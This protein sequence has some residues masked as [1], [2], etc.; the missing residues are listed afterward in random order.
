MKCNYCGEEFVQT[1]GNQKYCS[2]HCRL[3]AKKLLDQQ[4]YT[5]KQE[6]EEPL[7]AECEYC[8]EVFIKTHG[9]QKYCSPDCQYHADLEQNAD[10]RMKSYHK[11]KE[12]GGDK[13][14]GLGSGGLGPHRHED[15]ELEITKIHNEFKRLHLASKST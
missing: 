5:Q 11:N 6:N 15:P 10:A 8:H 3:E 2:D 1:H 4:Y 7:I 14:W 13:F 12:R 9:N